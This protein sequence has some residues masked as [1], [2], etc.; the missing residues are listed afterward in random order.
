MSK[1][2]RCGGNGFC[3]GTTG[4]N[5]GCDTALL[6]R[7]SSG[8]GSVYSTRIRTDL[9]QLLFGKIIQ[10]VEDNAGPFPPYGMEY[11][12]ALARLFL[13]TR[14]GISETFLDSF[15]QKLNASN[16]LDGLLRPSC[17][18]FQERL[19]VSHRID[20]RLVGLILKRVP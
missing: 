3:L 14:I 7:R 20:A 11:P 10:C 18:S 17:M 2:R 6:R 16:R 1:G 12:E 15:L 8:W 5:S 4:S 9:L 19:Y 13:H